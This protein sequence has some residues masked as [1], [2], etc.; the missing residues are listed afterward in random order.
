MLDRTIKSP[1]AIHRHLEQRLPDFEANGT[2]ELLKG[3]LVNYVWRVAGHPK[4][5]IVKSAPPYVATV[6]D[7]AL[8]TWR[9]IIEGRS[10]EAFEPGGLLAGIGGLVI[11]PPGLIDLDQEHYILVMEDVGDH[12]DFGA[13]LLRGRHR[14][15]SGG[16]IGRMVGQFIGTLHARSYKDQRLAKVF[17]NTP[18]QHTRLESQYRGIKDLCVRAGLPDADA[19]GSAAVTFGEKLQQPGLCVIMGDLWPRSLLITAG[20]VRIIDWEFAHFGRP[21]QDVAHLVAHLWMHTHCAPTDFV[22]AQA[23]AALQGFLEDYRLTLGSTFETLFG[24]DGL[25]ESAI[26]FGAEVLVRTV[27]AFQSGYLY[28]GLSPNDPKVQEAVAVA[29]AHIRSPESADT[30]VA[31]T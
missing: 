9:I 30:L 10:L 16:D 13:W 23:Q 4:P 22:A 31:L 20:G 3:G 1:S 27:G 12:Q 18:I 14:E 8:D 7:I 28:D 17:D 26:H 11:H 24:A 2:P 6:P 5:V 21:A 29:A 25:R 15:A 19:L